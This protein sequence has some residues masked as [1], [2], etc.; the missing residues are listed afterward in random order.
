MT[1][2]SKDFLVCEWMRNDLKLSGI[3]LL[4]Y[5]VIFNG[6]LHETDITLQEIG[7][8]LDIKE[9]QEINILNELISKGLVMK[10]RQGKIT[11]YKP[12]ENISIGAIDYSIAVLQYCS[13]EKK[14][15]KRKELSKEYSC[16]S[17]SNIKEDTDI[18]SIRDNDSS[19]DRL[20]C[21]LIRDV[22]IPKKQI[23]KTEKQKSSNAILKENI[24]KLIEEYTE[25]EELKNNLKEFVQMRE[26]Q[27]K[28]VPTE[29][30]MDLLLRRLTK[31]SDGEMWKK[32][33][34][35]EKSLIRC[36]SDFYELKQE[37]YTKT[38]ANG[39]IVNDVNRKT[40]LDDIF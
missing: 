27:K 4:I 31:Y 2:E 28:P 23:K 19:N 3:Q 11:V 37:D 22:S 32:R 5:A 13:L 20:R 10:S 7:K 36:W 30:A 39:I 6:K 21:S 9:R 12:C 18:E 38:T 33:L 29:H 8:W 17:Y 26:K 25:D 16:D 15:T 35:V 40:D 34:I 24:Q 1:T 14:S